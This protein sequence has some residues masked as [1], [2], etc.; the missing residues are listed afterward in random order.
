VTRPF[1]PSLAVP[2]RAVQ[3]RA[4]LKNGDEAGR[5]CK[6]KAIVG[7]LVCRSHGAQLP[8]VQQAAAR[9]VEGA[10]LRLLLAT[11]DAVVV[12]ET[13]MDEGQ[14]EAVRLRAAVEILDRAGIRG[15][16][17]IR[18][19]PVHESPAE[20]LQQRLATLSRRM[21]EARDRELPINE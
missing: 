20:E 12:L 21:S 8:A 18:P 6:K 15:G 7:G 3:C 2:L 9:A 13:L 5:R 4:P 10:R 17:E 19:L 16:V 14:N 11:E 1:K